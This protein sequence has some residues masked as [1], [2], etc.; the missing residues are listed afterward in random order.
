MLYK[1]QANTDAISNQVEVADYFGI[2]RSSRRG[3]TVHAQN[4]KVQNEVI[5]AVHRR[6][7]EALDGGSGSIRLD[8][9]DVYTP[10]DAIAPTLLEYSNAF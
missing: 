5:K 9:I 4:R 7:R 6:R 10:L 2:L 1:V 3:A 8:L